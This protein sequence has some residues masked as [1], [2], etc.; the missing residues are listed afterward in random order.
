MAAVVRNLPIF[1]AHA[2]PLMPDWPR[3]PWYQP[4]MDMGNMVH[5]LQFPQEETSTGTR[6]LNPSWRL[7][8]VEVDLRPDV[9]P[10]IPTQHSDAAVRF[11]IPTKH[12]DQ[13]FRPSIPT[14]HSDPAFRSS[15]PIQHSDPAFRPSIPTQ[16]SDPALITFPFNGRDMTTGGAARARQLP[17]EFEWSTRTI[18]LRLTQ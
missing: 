11:S 12:S 3:Q 8:Q 17:K 16:H 18:G 2:L 1:K 4:A 5:R 7:L 15:I 6:R 10:S 9:H 13:A 14:K